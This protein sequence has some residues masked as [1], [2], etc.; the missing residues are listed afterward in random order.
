MKSGRIIGW[1]GTIDATERIEATLA[2]RFGVVAFDEGG[3][4]DD[5]LSSVLAERLALRLDLSELGW[6]DVQEVL[7]RSAK[8]INPS[9]A[10]W[11]LNSAG[12]HFNQA[13]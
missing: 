10:E 9:E 6:R 7:I 12:Y 5:P 3:S 2:T 11:A 4:D 13:Y 1:I 8:K